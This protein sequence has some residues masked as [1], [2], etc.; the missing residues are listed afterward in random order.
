MRLKSL[1]IHGF[2][3][4]PDRTTLNFGEGI[5]AVVGPNG[6]GKSNI[7]DAVRWVLGE[8]STKSLRGSK[9]EEVIFD[10]TAIRRPQGFAEV[11]LCVDNTDRK[12]DFDSD[13]V[14]VTR[15]YF[16][17]GESEYKLN[18]TTVRLKDIHELFM[19]T[20]LGR[21]GYS[22]IGQGKIA[23]IVSSKSQGRREI[24]EE[25]AG[26]SKY[27][28][29]K[30]DA[31]RRLLRAED[32]LLRLKDILAELEERVGPL[33]TQSEKAKVFI[34][35]EGERKELEIGVWLD[36]IEKSRK[37]VREEKH[38]IELSQSQKKD[39]EE[40]FKNIE[41]ETE[42]ITNAVNE[43]TAKIDEIKRQASQNEETALTIE[44]EIA[45]LHTKITHNKELTERLKNDIS[46]TKNSGQQVAL[47]SSVID[48][49]IEELKV[50]IKDSDKDLREEEEKLYSLINEQNKSSSE[51]SNLRETS[52]KTAGSLSELKVET[53]TL[54]SNS[55]Q[56][57]NRKKSID[58]DLTEKDSQIKS[59]QKE[60]DE[61]DKSLK[62]AK[63]LEDDCKNSLKGYE[64]RVSSRREK[65]DEAENALRKLDGDIYTKEQQLTMLRQLERNMEGFAHS[66][67]FI[68]K[69]SE[70]G[71]LK[72]ICGVVSRLISSDPQYSV[73][74]EVA[75][76]AAV[77]HIIVKTQ[78]DAKSAIRH[79]KQ[80]KAGRATFLPIDSVKAKRFDEK[81][82]D[83]EAGFIGIASDL[84]DC[85]S[86]Y[87]EIVDSLLGRTVV[88][89]DLD[90]ATSIAKKYGYRFKIVTLDGQVVN[91][92]SSLTGGSSIKSA[93]LFSRN[94]DIE[95]LDK[96]IKSLTDKRDEQD[97][98]LQKRDEELSH[99]KAELDAC[100]SELITAREDL[101]RY[102]GELKRVDYALSE[103]LSA[104]K[105]LNDEKDNFDDF[106]K[107][108]QKEL[109]V[110]EAEIA[111]LEKELAQ[112]DEKIRSL[113]G[114]DDELKA[115][116]DEQAEQISNIKLQ[117]FQYEKDIESKENYKQELLKIGDDSSEKIAS[118]EKEIESLT[119]QIEIMESQIVAKQNRIT[120]LRSFSKQS[121][122][123][124]TEQ[125]AERLK[126][127]Q[128]L[129]QI[130]IEE[131]EKA[132]EVERISG[133]IARLTERKDA[134]VKEQDT[135]I[136]KLYT[137][138][139][140]TLS[141][142]EKIDVVIDDIKVAQRRLQELKNKIRAL[143][144]VNV[145]A[146][147]EYKEVSERY[148]FMKEQL[149]DV[150][151]SKA[152]LQKLISDLTN[153][154]RTIFGEKFTEINQ[155]FQV[156]F[157]ELFEGG[158][159]ELRLSD[160]SNVL[161]ADI[162]MLIQPPGKKV[163]NIDLLSG[164]E[165]A[166]TA[167]AL[168]FAILS[169]NPAPFC[170]VDEIEAA[171]DDVNVDRFAEYLRK[172][173]TNTQ[174]IAI[175]HRRGTMEEAD[176]LYGVTMQ[177][178]GVSKLLAL[179]ISEVQKKTGIKLK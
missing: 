67:K 131:R 34:E 84:V 72:G 113:T 47:E 59:L 140:L 78:S 52:L 21:D 2:K 29:R 172:M 135:L 102:D 6:S 149:D 28:Y 161:E 99:A 41:T 74:I 71:A 145:A 157:K 146:I 80:N 169:V 151:R 87:R 86:D 173:S 11:T 110:K 103:L 73:A 123:V 62:K 58:E 18:D 9:M 163:Q 144:S 114:S 40:S 76:G 100:G 111:K 153:S 15:R 176:M 46:D 165:K 85:K 141:E 10:G 130:R 75:L 93:G 118:I 56:S 164:G 142:A 53:A 81:K 23:E 79:L 162:E 36:T 69:E 120:E 155:R 39:A 156:V 125:V 147:E 33:K 134:L 104:V 35:L 160:E 45:V 55:E 128:R 178:K 89:N 42:N 66:T 17:S 105:S 43:I 83:E 14:M 19:D 117:I 158:S 137:E 166:L 168:Y 143:G 132:V 91:A 30:V 148:E 49:Q 7:S 26:I 92:G 32:N 27:R 16:R 171:L 107:N 64:M 68:I 167:I 116:R 37:A 20:G 170:V 101:I 108:S 54:K 174:F 98:I 109:L 133:E 122:D 77:G 129:S 150:E 25:A 63:D 119:E 175:T 139:E 13:E 96:E 94:A 24:F 136:E 138:Y 152:E 22:M 38:K 44:G 1:Q 60:K 70:N 95:K 112:T 97:K 50:K 5:T 121:D 124:I 4:F 82:I 31:E 57:E 3:S 126:L 90:S 65:R 127:E 61:I 159:G 115:K 8:Q 177:E 179:N 88:V 106:L 51:I 48:N 12:L 154:M